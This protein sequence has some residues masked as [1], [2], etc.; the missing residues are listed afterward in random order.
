[1]GA[2]R[3]WAR[4]TDCSEERRSVMG[5]E[6]TFLPRWKAAS[7]RRIGARPAAPISIKALQS[8]HRVPFAGSGQRIPTRERAL[9]RESKLREAVSCANS[10]TQRARHW[11]RV[12]SGC[13]SSERQV[14]PLRATPDF[15]WNLVA[16]A[17]FMCLSLRKGA[18]AASTS[19]SWQEIR[20]RAPIRMTIHLWY[21]HSL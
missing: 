6:L 20:V 8:Q 17:N 15:L 16:L 19:V 18:H 21:L 2:G 11:L 12:T 4:E 14:P 1:M 9:R 3:R 10:I 13:W 7:D 5:R